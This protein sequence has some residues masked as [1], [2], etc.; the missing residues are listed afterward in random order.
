[1][2]APRSPIRK[3]PPA[4]PS[5]AVHPVRTPADNLVLIMTGHIRTAADNNNKHG[6]EEDLAKILAKLG[7]FYLASKLAES[8]RR[9]L[10]IA[11]T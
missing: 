8:V 4:V 9:Y 5:R 6:H 10:N 2:Q 3:G 1:M 7:N 11:D